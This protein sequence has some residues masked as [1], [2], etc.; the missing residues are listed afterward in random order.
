MSNLLLSRRHVLLAS[1]GVAAAALGWRALRPDA[2]HAAI[3]TVIYKRLAYLQLD[4]AGVQQFAEDLV[5]IRMISPARLKI[6]AMI[7]PVYSHIDFAGENSLSRSVQHGEE[8]IASQYLLSS[9]FF[10]NGSDLQ[11]QVRYLGYYDAVKACGNP[12]ARPM[13]S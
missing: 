9:D 5:A 6:I 11:R 2:Q 4:P 8:R 7:A 12:F 1:A 10:V 3:A 13:Q